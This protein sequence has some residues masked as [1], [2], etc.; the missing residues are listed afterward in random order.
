MLRAT[1]EIAEGLAMPRMRILTTGH[2]SEGGDEFVSRTHVLRI[3][4]REVARWRPWTE[5]GGTVRALNPRAGR[6]QV[7]G[8]E[9]WSSDFDR[10]G[11]TPGLVVQPHVIPLPELN[12]GT[13]R[14]E[15]EIVDFDRSPAADESCYWQ[16]SA[17]VVADGEW[18]EGP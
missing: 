6:R 17:V 3:D 13:H 11:W 10:S 1:V 18:V 2:G 4:G 12:P 7:A 8:R 15:L 14:I 5:A 16:V 9:I